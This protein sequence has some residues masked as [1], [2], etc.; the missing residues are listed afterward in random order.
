[1]ISSRLK[2]FDQAVLCFSFVLTFPGCP[3]TGIC[4]QEPV[5]KF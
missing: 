3:S 5:P 1:M 2:A 4:W